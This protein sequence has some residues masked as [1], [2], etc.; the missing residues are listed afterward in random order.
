VLKFQT[1]LKDSHHLKLMLTDTQIYL[2][3]IIGGIT[4]ILKGATDAVKIKVNLRREVRH[5]RLTVRT[6][7]KGTLW[8]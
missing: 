5:M 4:L 1:T 6:Y 7:R 2:G 3:K 8:R